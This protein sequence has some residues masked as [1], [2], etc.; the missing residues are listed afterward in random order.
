VRQG[1]A[2]RPAVASVPAPAPPHTPGR[3]R[4]PSPTLIFSTKFRSSSARLPRTGRDPRLLRPPPAA[5]NPA[6]AKDA[7]RVRPPPGRRRRPTS[8]V[9]ERRRRRPTG[10]VRER[11]RRAGIRD[12]IPYAYREDG[13]FS[14]FAFLFFCSGY[15]GFIFFLILLHYFTP[16]GEYF[17]HSAS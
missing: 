10:R 12:P 15:W 9:R 8:R 17:S 3:V 7:C 4:T 16:I 13:I 11:R 2:G 1:G 5:A 6:A 14:S